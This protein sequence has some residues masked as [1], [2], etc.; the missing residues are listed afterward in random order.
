MRWTNSGDRLGLATARHDA[1]GSRKAAGNPKL[2]FPVDSVERYNES[3][4]TAELE[5][6]DEL[7]E[8][9]EPPDAGAEEEVLDCE[10]ELAAASASASAAAA[11][12]A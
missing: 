1:R 6:L 3:E 5:E 11:A 9:G 8:P 12:S 7:E 2:P 10:L 4:S